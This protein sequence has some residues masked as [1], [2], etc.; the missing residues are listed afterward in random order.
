VD[1]QSVK[2]RLSKEDKQRLDPMIHSLKKAIKGGNTDEIQRESD[3]F[4]RVMSSIGYAFD[5]TQ[6]ANDDGTFDSDIG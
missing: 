2:K 3:E 1:A 4:A 6:A 5:G